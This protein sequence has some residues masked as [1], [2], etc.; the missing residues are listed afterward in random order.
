MAFTHNARPARQPR[1]RLFAHNR[2]LSKSDYSKQRLQQGRLCLMVRGDFDLRERDVW[3]FRAKCNLAFVLIRVA[4]N[5]QG[6]IL[7]ATVLGSELILAAG[8]LALSIQVR[9]LLGLAPY[10]ILACQLNIRI[11][12]LKLDSALLILAVLDRYCNAIGSL[13][14]RDLRIFELLFELVRLRFLD[15]VRFYLYPFGFRHWCSV[16][17]FGSPQEFVKQF[18]KHSLLLGFCD[19]GSSAGA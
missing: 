6:N 4:E 17:Q 2:N 19:L 5:E 14:N 8:K 15:I 18:V 9:P 12:G 16:S 10:K 3:F 7:I 11:P 1:R 13:L